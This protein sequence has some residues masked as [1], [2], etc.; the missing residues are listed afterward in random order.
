MGVAASCNA[1]HEPGDF[2]E[3]IA[4]VD[5]NRPFRL[6]IPP[7]YGA[8]GPAPLV[9]NFH[10]SN[11][12]GLHQE[13]YSGLVPIADREGFVLVS[14][15]AAGFG[16]W[17]IVG[18]YADIGIDDV[19]FTA[20]LLDY[21]ESSLCIDPDRVYAAG[22]SNGAEMASQAGCFFPE[23]F[24]AIA[25]VA[26]VTYQGCG[27]PPVPVISFHGT[28]DYNVP[29][30]ETP[31]AMEGWA[32]HNG[33]PA[34]LATEQVSEHVTRQ[35]YEGCD[36]AD[37]VLYVVDGG[38]HTWPGADETEGGVGFTTHEIDASELIWRFFSS[39]PKR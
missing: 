38:G 30:E 2:V 35:S 22:M 7:G 12:S 32:E 19:G 20:E 14:P 23:R 18:F 21:L 5:G 34:G 11:R 1:P 10:G 25:P 8:K 13:V 17:D 3:S 4:T 29:F 28:D 27:G 9:F 16:E 39:H 15:E 31:P 36:G 37:V 33:C 6:H 24:A 26:G